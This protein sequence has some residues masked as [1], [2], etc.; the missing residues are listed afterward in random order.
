MQLVSVAGEDQVAA[1][2]AGDIDAFVGHHPYLEQ[3]IIDHGALLLVHLTGADLPSIGE[4][5]MLVLVVPAG[6]SALSESLAAVVA[7]LA[8]AQTAIREDPTVATQA[9][10]SAFPDLAGPLLEKGQAIY[11][12]GVPVTPAITQDAYETALSI[13]GLGPVPFDQVV[14]NS[15]VE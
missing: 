8:E 10:A 6:E 2:A 7:A 15:L 1:L 14:D 12:P 4:F 13:F 3:A 11:L 5:P 9:L